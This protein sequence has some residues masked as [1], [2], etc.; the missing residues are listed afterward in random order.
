M[1][2]LALN[3][4][5]VL[6]LHYAPKFHTGEN[7]FQQFW[8]YKYNVN[9]Y[10][11]LTRLLNNDFIE[12][13]SIS[14]SLKHKTMNELKFILNDCGMKTS[15]RK[16]EL[17]D[18]LTSN[19][20]KEQI[21]TYIPEQYYCLTPLGQD[22]L[23]NNPNII[24]VHQHPEFELDIYSVPP[25]GDIYEY[26]IYQIESKE[27]EYIYYNNWGLYRNCK[28]Q[29]ANIANLK[30]D[31]LSE[32]MYYFEIC[33]I[34]ISGLGN[35]VKPE[36]LLSTKEY[37]R[38]S[39]SDPTKVLA[40]GIIERIRFIAQKM[41]L[42]YEDLSSICKKVIVNTHLPFHLYDDDEALNIILQRIYGTIRT[43]NSE[44]K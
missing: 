5:E 20:S 29:R 4:I 43:S 25:D 34:D 13:D 11:L 24:F 9:P 26:I 35:G 41:R 15:G 18:R 44:L 21:L 42:K 3:P 28:Y 38:S 7:E 12:I 31:A 39:W 32:L 22:V 23:K 14:N 40:I 17:I 1:A 10:E 27:A 16:N 33:Y 19:F 8:K 6:M 36:L 30:E 37:T 2:I